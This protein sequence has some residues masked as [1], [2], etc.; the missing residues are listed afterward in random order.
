ML[1]IDPK[2]VS[3]GKLHAYMLSSV[4]PRPIAFASTIDKDGKPN[5]APFSFFN[6]F[7]SNPP[8]LIFSPARRV[9]DNTIKHTL[10]NVRDVAEVVVNVVS[11]KMVHQTSLASMEYEKEVNE[12]EK[13]GFTAIESKIVKPFRVKE[14]PV[15]FECMVKEV[16]ELGTEGGAGN[17][18]V[19]EI[20]MMHINEEIL[21]ED[22]KIDMNKI[23]LVG[24]MGGN[25][26]SRA[27][28]AAVFQVMKPGLNIGIGFDQ[29]P[30]EIQSSSFL[31]G[32]DLGKLGQIEKLPSN[33]DIEEYSSAGRV[34]ELKEKYQS[35][36]Q[37]LEDQLHQLA[38]EMLEED[39][40]EEAWKVLLS[41]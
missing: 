12:F 21:D 4:M 31:T 36:K 37:A 34:N 16:I 41:S 13:A 11:Y 38:H 6:A 32:N 8:T 18:I 20:V 14:S 25:N 29:M 40:V 35:D 3:T 22:G 30:A 23:D 39:K 2:E 7:S 28:G 15:Q 10:E 33:G 26:Y 19:C 1:K 5:L 17:L 9:K 27:S 24:R